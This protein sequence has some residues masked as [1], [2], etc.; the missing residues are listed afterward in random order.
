MTARRRRNTAGKTARGRPFTRGKDP[1]RGHGKPGRSGRKPEEFK[2][3]CGEQLHDKRKR[4]A[5]SQVLGNA[6]HPH[7]AK[8]WIWIASYGADR[9]PEELTLTV[10]DR[11]EHALNRILDELTAMGKRQSG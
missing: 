1:R 4:Q 5:I 6:D 3:W 11:R 10:R 7:F 8:M 9:P 2:R